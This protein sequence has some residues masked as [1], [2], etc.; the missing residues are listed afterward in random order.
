MSF[1]HEQTPSH[2]LLE[3]AANFDGLF[4]TSPEQF[5]GKILS[6]STSEVFIA[7]SALGQAVP[8]RADEI[9]KKLDIQQE[10]I[11]KLLANMNWGFDTN[12]VTYGSIGFIEDLQSADGSSVNFKPVKDRYICTAPAIGINTGDK[13]FEQIIGPVWM[14]EV[15]FIKRVR[16]MLVADIT[17]KRS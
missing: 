5:I 6:Q 8:S 13:G 15:E 7:Q 11:D 10:A 17:L 1:E 9:K 2:R 3:S 12:N 4:A 16:S 14:P